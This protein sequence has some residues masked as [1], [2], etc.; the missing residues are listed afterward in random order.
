MAG[1]AADRKAR[2]NILSRRRR[3]C[4]VGMRVIDQN[5]IR[6][7]NERGAFAEAVTG[8]RIPIPTQPSS[9]KSLNRDEAEY[10]RAI[11]GN[12][13]FDRR[14]PNEPMRSE[15]RDWLRA[16]LG[17]EEFARR[18]PDEAAEPEPPGYPGETALLDE[19]WDSKHPRRGGPRMQAGGRRQVAGPAAD[20]AGEV[21]PGAC[22][23]LAGRQTRSGRPTKSRRRRTPNRC[24]PPGTIADRAV[25]RCHSPH[26]LAHNLAGIRPVKRPH[27]EDCQAALLEDALGI[28]ST[29]MLAPR[30]RASSQPAT[31]CPQ[32]T[33]LPSI[34]WG[35]PRLY[36]LQGRKGAAAAVVDAGRVPAIR[37]SCISDRTKLGIDGAHASPGTAKVF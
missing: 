35:R 14:F 18:I 27:W 17:P 22:S 12:E 21:R 28:F 29:A 23:G 34:F 25:R 33:T 6:Q 3:R 1:R 16:V 7:T 4:G 36:T 32:F 30:R 26:D 8:R 9:K 31:P 2:T 19:I 37:R 10:L 5:W 24:L 11:L 20:R 13:E 15:H